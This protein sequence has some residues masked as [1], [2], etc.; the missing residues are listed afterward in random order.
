MLE[1]IGSDQPLANR[2]R[3]RRVGTRCALV[4]T[5]AAATG[6]VAAGC[7]GSGGST[8]TA[9]TVS[10]AHVEAAIAQSVRHARHVDASVTCPSGVPV[11]KHAH[12]YCVAQVGAQLTPFRV[13]ETGDGGRV[14]WVGVSPSHTH[15]LGT[16][17]VAK[18]IVA[19]IKSSR[20]VTAVVRC[21][22]V[23][24]MQRGLPFAC[25]AKTKSGDTHFEV[26]QTDSHGHVTYHAL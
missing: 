14:T 24:P 8:T 6:L 12:F 2:E 9:T 15:L 23:I 3:F 16:T 1:R 18:A 20:G 4:I 19:S 10:P 11:R 26:R 25:T 21:P 22:T 13:T 5:A 17:S 7:G